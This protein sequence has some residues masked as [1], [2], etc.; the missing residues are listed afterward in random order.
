MDPSSAAFPVAFPRDAN[1]G[2]SGGAPARLFIRADVSK[3][4]ATL[5]FSIYDGAQS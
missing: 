4:L 1:Y 3:A 5:K 2:R